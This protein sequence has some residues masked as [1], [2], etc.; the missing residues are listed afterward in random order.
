VL[1]K[2]RPQSLQKL[3]W[4]R[5][6][7]EIRNS[8]G[9][10]I[11]SQKNI[12]APRDWS[13][14]AVEIAASRYFRRTG[15]QSRKTESSIQQLTERVSQSIARSSQRQGYFYPAQAKLFRQQIEAIV[16]SQKAL[17]NS[18]VWFN[19]GLFE[20][21]KTRSEVPTFAFDSKTKKIKKYANG[22]E[23]PQVSA[24]FIQSIEDDLESI[25]EFAKKEARIF[26]YGSGSG[27][28]FSPLRSRYEP[29]SSGGKSSGLIAFLE[30]LDRGAGAIKSGGVNRRAAKMVCLNIDHPEVPEFI[31]WKMREEE[32]AKALIAAGY[33]S[34][35]E[36]EAYQTISGQNANNSI[37]VVSAF[38]KALQKKSKWPLKNF[39]SRK[40][41]RKIPAQK[42]W[43]QL[44]HAAWSCADPG[45]Q[46][47]DTIQKWNPCSVSGRIN[48]SNPCSEYM[49]LDNTAC[50]LA[51]LNLNQFFAFDRGSAPQFLWEDFSKV[52][53]T[54]FT[55]QD[56]LID[57]AG[58]PTEEIA[59][60]SHLYRPLG[61][62]FCGL[63]GVLMKMGLSYNSDPARAWAGFLAAT[64]QAEALLTSIELAKKMGPFPRFKE[65]KKS[66]LKVLKMHEQAL[67][68]IDW[69]HLPP[70]FKN[71]IFSLY[72]N[73][74]LLA[75]RY[76]IRNAQLTCMAPTGT[77]G[78]V[79]D[80][81]TTG[82]EPEYSLIKFK[83]LVGGGVLKIVS[84]SVH[85]GLK[86][87]GY[88]GADSEQILNHLE[89]EGRIDN[90]ELLKPQHHSVF[91][92]A[93]KNTSSDQY[94]SPESHLLMMAAIQ[95]FLS[96]AISKT[97]NLPESISE[98]EI[99]DLYL[100]AWKLGLKSIAVYRDQ[101]KGN[102]PLISKANL[103]CPEC[104]QTTEIAGNCYRCSNC[105]FTTGCV[106]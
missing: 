8:K 28:N 96:G 22:L 32:K 51:S 48:A 86:S 12:L 67:K 88:S 68:K 36:G 59:M 27:A 3:E 80:C 78:L 31:D 77:I 11:F 54:I 76:G 21:Y 41:I 13:Q 53:R 52:V 43:Q 58:Y 92:T 42:L 104:G 87:L 1:G 74:N 82:I 2:S 5:F 97:V 95:P 4:K 16:Y 19:C 40:T 99:S 83:K 69:S 26:K 98:K 106:S 79:M 64:L 103:V 39:H 15:S 55:A 101:S 102:Q 75:P 71:K 89:K 63:G 57:Q 84:Q 30:V 72:K 105:G 73:I 66:T 25:F 50:N 6:N 49:F 14:T 100:K 81:D 90:C 10:V 29:L 18:P 33:S 38:F 45:L 24:C 37:R 17:F 91:L 62:G 60:N 93:Q 70:E 44:T 47:E 94:L 35:M 85:Q 34:E 9:E 56:V 20:T 23:R 65:N 61:L 46:F 7:A